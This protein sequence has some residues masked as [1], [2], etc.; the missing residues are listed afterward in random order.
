MVKPSVE[1]LKHIMSLDHMLLRRWQKQSEWVRWKDCECIIN[2]LPV[3]IY[4]SV[5]HSVR[6]NP[7]GKRTRSRSEGK[8][9]LVGREE[10]QTSTDSWEVTVKVCWK[11]NFLF[12]FVKP[13]WGC[14]LWFSSISRQKLLVRGCFEEVKP[15]SRA[16]GH[17]RD[18]LQAHNWK[19]NKSKCS[20][21]I[22]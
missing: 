4:I 13:V 18:L 8:C 5:N 12:K 10:R 9:L 7:Q 22:K 14:V 6:A 21:D 19:R 11:E 2:I 20:T 1:L 17:G 3:I 15:H 16:I